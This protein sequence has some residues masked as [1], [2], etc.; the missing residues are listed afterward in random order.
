M[1][2]G[3][4]CYPS[5][6]GSG[7]VASELGK[8]LMDRGHEIH[9]FSYDLPH[10][11]IGESRLFNFHHVDVPLYPVFRFP[12]Y[13]LALATRLAEV[14]EREQL[15]VI[16][17]HYAI[18]HSTSALLAKMMVC[19]YNR[20]DLK[21]ITTL[22]GTD[23]DLV[24]WEP[25]Y[26][27]IVEYSIN[28]SDAVTA[29]SEYLK[30]ATLE[31]FR[32]EREI[33]VIHNPIDTHVFRPPEHRAKEEGTKTILHIS[34]FRP[35]KRVQDAVKIL[36]LVRNCLPVRLVFLGDG[37]DRPLAERT[38]RQLGVQDLV[39]FAGSTQNIEDWLRQGDLL[40]STSS[41]ESFGMSIAEAMA[42]GLPVVA[43][44]VGGIPEVVEEGVQ[45]RLVEE[46]DVC[47]AARAVG[48]ILADPELARVYGR[49]ARTRIESNFGHVRIAERYESLYRSLF[50][51][52][53]DKSSPS[54]N[55]RLICDELF[56]PGP[57]GFPKRPN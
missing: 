41:M 9:F 45:G 7:I 39:T 6:G 57:A 47:A 20:R 49:N 26:R 50:G 14:A 19:H 25:S 36:D 2:I 28:N 35:V 31:K 44:R 24:G 46:G 4:V 8:G 53:G 32:I 5:I 3:I 23:I 16:H 54:G 27:T 34:N 43:Y 56:K 37:P 15:D 21:I 52:E 48:S 11:L 1:K 38:A 13:T 40:L 51:A 30:R 17:V 42:T 29:V 10:R 22:H 18:P 55:R 12:P 33:E